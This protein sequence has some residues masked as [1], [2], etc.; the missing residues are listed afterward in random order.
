[1]ASTVKDSLMG[2]HYD[3]HNVFT[4]SSFAAI[5]T[6]LRTFL[7]GEY[8]SGDSDQLYL[9]HIILNDH[10]YTACFIVSLTSV[11]FDKSWI[12]MLYLQEQNMALRSVQI[13]EF[14]FL[15]MSVS[16]PYRDHWADLHVV[17]TGV[18][19]FLSWLWH[20]NITCIGTSLGHK[21][22]FGT[23]TVV[24][25]FLL[26]K[27]IFHFTKQYYYAFSIAEYL[28][29]LVFFMAIFLPFRTAF[30]S[31]H[32]NNECRSLFGKNERGHI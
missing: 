2:L 17:V 10:F 8:D 3:F 15:V 19:F 6:V 9:S 21:I 30:C 24:Y 4:L 7:L 23:S 5:L 27:T 18:G 31:A 13:L 1:M 29:V 25:S 22:W 26:L 11:Y 28:G 16:V 32:R 20:F 12:D 14:L